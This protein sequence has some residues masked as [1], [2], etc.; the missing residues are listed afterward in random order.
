MSTETIP[1][2]LPQK[3]GFVFSEPLDGSALL[4]CAG[5]ELGLVGGCFILFFIWRFYMRWNSEGAVLS[6]AVL[7]Y[8]TLK[9]MPEG[10]CFF[11]G[12]YR[13]VWVYTFVW[14]AR[15]QENSLAS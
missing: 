6:N 3:N 15:R 14:M 4:L 7:I 11:P 9:L 1:Q 8:F 12:T 13:F 10:H 2:P 5:S